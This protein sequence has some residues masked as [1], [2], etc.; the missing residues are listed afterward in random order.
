GVA[1]GAVLFASV[2][3]A[4]AA[5]APS[6]GSAQSFA[7]LA[8][9]TVTNT[10]PTT[11]TG[12]L[13]VSP[14]SA[15]TGLAS[16]TLSGAT[17]AADAVALQAQTD[18]TT[19]YNALAA[20]PCT[21]SFTGTAVELGGQTLTPGVYCYSSSAQLTGTL[22]LNGGGVFIFKIASTLTTAANSTVALIGG[23]SPCSVF[24][25]IGSSAALFPNTTFVGSMLAL[26]S[27]TLQTGARLSG[28]ALARNGAVTMDTNTVSAGASCAAA[29]TATP[30][31][32]PSATPTATPAATPTATPAATSTATPSVVLPGTDTVGA[33]PE[34][35]FSPW[36]FVLVAL[37]LG[38]VVASTG[39]RAVRGRSR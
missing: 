12:D 6:L 19:A 34:G 7:V 17:H 38:V 16:I 13:G 32:T 23:A 15:I 27:I 5:T 11:I 1:A 10:G 28:Q 14:G 24:W 9:T 2:Y 30:T 25:Q 4:L 33:P 36:P 3:P 35:G 8:G 26:T 39:S 20:A 21:Q 37:F 22:T 31:A 29:P 18:V